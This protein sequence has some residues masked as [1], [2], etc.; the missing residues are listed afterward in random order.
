MTILGGMADDPPKDRRYFPLTRWSLLSRARRPDDVERKGALEELAR[1]YW[2]PL[3]CFVSRS[4][5][6]DERAMDLV[7]GFFL[8]L[9]EK[10]LLASFDSARGKFRTYLLACLK[11]HLGDERD[12]ADALK[13]GGGRE[14]IALDTE[15][16]VR[17][18][19][20]GEMTPDEAYDRAW[21][22]AKIDWAVSKVRRD[23]EAGGE[24]KA[25]VVLE[26]YLESENLRR[27]GTADLAARAAL[28]EVTVRHLLEY[29]RKRI[30]RTLVEQ[31]LEETSGRSDAEEEV[32]F[33]FD[34]LRR[35]A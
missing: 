2:W 23:L 13:R 26:G 19:P 14:A 12:R 6:D 31:L 15:S 22:I 30:K 7:Q 9:L 28:P 24:A 18:L 20:A 27:P 32:A 33:L 8:S 34:C 4:G 11:G 17:E 25:L 1:A 10:D 16:G 35:G 29:V 5:G 21:A 3:Y